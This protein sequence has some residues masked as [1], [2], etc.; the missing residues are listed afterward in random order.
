[1]EPTIILDVLTQCN[2]SVKDASEKLLLLGYDKKETVLAP[3]KLKDR[4]D[5]KEN[6]A[7]PKPSPGPP[8]PKNLSEKHKKKG[9]GHL[10]MAEHIVG[11]HPC[12]I[13]Y[14]AHTKK[15]EFSSKKYQCYAN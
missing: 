2:Y 10:N 3:P 13:I 4:P 7:A 14:L 1:M 8:R 6:K 11:S 12:C 15:T 5:G 9:T